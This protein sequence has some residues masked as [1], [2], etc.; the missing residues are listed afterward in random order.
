MDVNSL[1]G[2]EYAVYI[3]FNK[4]IYEREDINRWIEFANNIN[5]RFMDKPFP[6]IKYIDKI[7]IIQ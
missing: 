4:E 6:P 1:Y 3:L 2:L 7:K 5:I